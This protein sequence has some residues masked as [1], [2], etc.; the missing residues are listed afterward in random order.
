MYELVRVRAVSHPRT[1]QPARPRIPGERFVDEVADSRQLLADWITAEDNPYFATAIVNRLWRFLMGRG[2]I[3]PT[4]DVRP[5]NP[6]SHPELLKFLAQDFVA[7]NCDIRHTVRMIAKS[8]TY[9]RTSDA[10]GM[11]ASDTMFYSHALTRPLESEVLADALTHVTGIAPRYGDHP[12]G[13]R[14]VSLF[15]PTTPSASLDILGRCSREQS[16]ESLV[17]AIS[18][19]QSLHMI[20]GALINDRILAKHSRLKRMLDAN[21]TNEQIIQTFYTLALSRLPSPAESDF[22]SVQ[23]ATADI[24]D[25]VEVLGDF[26]WSLLACRE[27]VTNH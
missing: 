16:C 21:R 12:E 10:T 24:E 18:L 13:T 15:D 8:A 19:E 2:L 20:N 6:P 26:V 7:H 23:L 27:F 11:N 17:Q 14:A 25:R 3:E 9:A 22:W 4:D 5:T 1:G